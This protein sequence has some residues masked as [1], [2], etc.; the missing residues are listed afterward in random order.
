MLGNRA[1]PDNVRIH[2]RSTAI[3]AGREAAKRGSG[4]RALGQRHEL[5]RLAQDEIG[6][7]LR[8]R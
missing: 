8:R 4:V 2:S 3:R 6:E 7:R 1:A 5:R